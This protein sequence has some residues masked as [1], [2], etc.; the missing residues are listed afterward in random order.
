MANITRIKNNQITDANV[1]AFAK[2]QSGTITG[3]L[4]APSVTINSNVTITGNLTLTGTTDSI[5]ATNTYVNDP[6]VVFN[7]GF[8]GTPSYDI[9]ILVNRNLSSLPGYGAVNTAWIWEETSQSFQGIATTEVGTTQGQLNNSG[10]A[11]LRIGNI[12]ACSINTTTSITSTGGG[13]FNGPTQINSTLGVTGIV[14]ITN[15]TAATAPSTGAL[16]VSGGA[17]VAGNVW[18]GGS[19]NVYLGVTPS[20]S[21][22]T[23]VLVVSGG[24]G[25]AGNVIAGGQVQANNGLYSLSTFNGGY[26]DGIVVDY[27]SGLGRISVGGGDGVNIYNGGVANT[28]LLQISSAGVV[29]VPATTTSSAYTNGALVVSGGAGFNG[30][31][32]ANG[33]VFIPSLAYYGFSSIAGTGMYTDGSYLRFAKSGSDAF[34]INNTGPFSLQQ[35][36]FINGSASAP[37]IVDSSWGSSGFYFPASGVVGIAT[38]S[39][40]VAAFNASSTPTTST[41]TGAFVL[42][43]GAGISG[44]LY[45]GGITNITGATTLTTVTVGGAQA[46]A[47]GNVTPG[48]GNF[49]YLQGTNFSSGNAVVT[50]GDIE[51]TPIGTTIPSTA[52]FTTATTG[53]LQA[54]A[55]GN[56]T[57]GTGNFTTLQGTNFSSGNAVITGGSVNASPVGNATPSTGAFTTLSAS[58]SATFNTSGLVSLAPT[59]TG[60]VTI[61]PNTL[62]SIDNMAIGATTPS[63]AKFTT[64]TV[65][66]I[67]TAQ[68]ANQNVLLGAASGSGVTTIASGATGTLDNINIGATTPATGKFTTLQSTGTTTLAL[69]TAAAI[70]STPIGN[71]TPSTAA[72]TTLTASGATTVTNGT[73]STSTSTGALVVTGGVGV[74][75]DVWI[76]GNLNVQGVGT[77]TTVNREIITSTEVVGGVLTANSGTASTSTT[78]GALLVSGGAGITGAV[79]AGSIQATPIGSTTAST[80]V[81]TTATTGGLQ[82]VAIGNVTPGSGAFTTLTASGLT[83]ITNATASTLPTNGALVVTGGVGIEGALN[84]AGTSSFAGNMSVGNVLVTGNINAAVGAVASYNGL[85]YGNA[86]TGFG[87]LYAG[88][89][90]GYSIVPN[91]L[92]QFTGNG[93]SY[94]QINTQNLSTGNQATTD[95][96]ATANNGTDTTYYVD[97]GIAGSNYNNANPNN[98]LGTSLFPNDAYLYAQGQTSS[99]GGNLVVGTSVAGTLVKVIAG[100][101]NATNVIATYSA[102]GLTVNQTTTSTSSSTGALQV[103]GGVGITG[104]LNVGGNFGVTGTFSTTNAQITGGAITSTPI[105]GAVGSFTYLTATT[106]FSTSNVLISGGSINGTTLG[107]TTPST[108]VFTY[109]NATTGFSTANAWIS[110]GNVVSTAITGTV[111]T[112][113]VAMYA[114]VGINANNNTFYPTFVGATS[115]NTAEYVNTS[116][117]FNPSTGTLGAT[118]FSGVGSFSTASTSGVFVASGNIVATASTLNNRFSTTTGALIVPNGGAAVAGNLSVGSGLFVGT[119]MT[120]A[121]ANGLVAVGYNVNNYAQFA[122]QNAN[123]GNNAST[124]IAAVANN[125]SDNDTYIDVGITSSAYSQ[126]A[127]TL[128]G[129]NDGY[130]VV[131]GN[132]TTGGGNL[133]LN[134]YQAN[135]IIF[136]AGGTQ[137]NNEV[138]RITHGNVL[139]V[140]STNNGAPAANVGALQVW[141]GASISSNVYLGGATTI[142]GSQTVGNDVIVRGHTDSTLIWGRPGTT[143]DQ[144]VIGGSATTGTLTQFAKLAIN[145]VDSMIVPVGTSAQ[146]P[147]N[148]GG[149]DVAGML[150]FNTTTGS[151]EWFNG[152]TWF[153]AGTTF[154]IIVDQ[155]FNGD[156][157]TVGFTLSKSATTAGVLISINGVVQIPTLAYAVAGTTL[158][159]TEAPQVGDVID[160]RILTT[161]ATVNSLSS[162]T[163]STEV[164]L[165]QTVGDNTI[166]FITNNTEAIDI[167]P[168]GNFV[169]KVAGRVN[170]TPSITVGTSSTP[171]DAWSAS[172]YKVAKYLVS[173]HNAGNTVF[174]ALEALVV[175]DG[176]ST[177]NITSYNTVNAGGSTQVS[178]TAAIAGG[179]V[180]V[181]ATGVGAG[182]VVKFDR[183]YM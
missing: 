11:N 178:L 97:L 45:V 38:G 67:L 146:R 161:Q 137:A 93:N 73:A 121:P 129:A 134:T 49:T 170:A 37:A 46:L 54:V 124:D 10:Y 104:D 130:L 16:Q 84:V 114:N 155:Q 166:R 167:D 135:D 33:N 148:L 113:N 168:N 174:T 119:A 62:G 91:E 162:A 139:L 86:Q 136:A 74:G 128:Y 87:A 31:I 48:T 56:V 133:I 120:Y 78:T 88:L 111:A 25:V 150:R 77:T 65:T 51:N 50:G 90:S 83:T 76:A 153:T 36:Q 144:V 173:A 115:G 154:T 19:Q 158:T 149:T 132:T 72:F 180:T 60:T 138:A 58:T 3:N 157:S 103:A 21:T 35:H 109:L 26:T 43:G 29:T 141:G 9:G 5:S 59:G 34:I 40:Q 30:N 100:G 159:F 52:K 14:S 7:N 47:I 143:Y 61:N 169:Q 80:A 151:V 69:T 117:T 176:A 20:T 85:F 122:I 79:Y 147:S 68:T 57:P 152:S 179:Q 17:Y 92:A 1:V 108:G 63:T 27:T 23:G 81:F 106:G 64:T 28:A 101:V 156:G 102:T 6:L 172:T 116:L 112:A 125:G 42:T 32:N 110:G 145:S 96:V 44:N 140:K 99:N 105:S 177:V 55:I 53:G 95:W 75:G 24:T 71:S 22:S 18:V 8:N 164:L 123:A 171:L 82:A 39:S 160:V 182:T 142:N 175:T 4:F 183:I 126:S 13:T 12:T 181:S 15:S 2:L 165:D 70:N 127:Y 66:G 118:T 41:T 131:A 94:V 163:G 107:A 98:S 89:P